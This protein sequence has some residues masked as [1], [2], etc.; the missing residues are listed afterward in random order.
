MKKIKILA[1]LAFVAITSNV[2][3]QND[4]TDYR[5]ELRFGLKAGLNY[6]NVY[7]EKTEDFNSD[8]K[9]GFVGG[10]FLSIPINKYLGVQPEVLFSQ[11]GF[12]GDGR[13]LGSKYEF[14]RT[15]S[16]IDVPIQ[17]AFKPS[18]FLTVLAGPQYSYLMNQKDDFNSSMMSYSQE[19]E[20]KNNNIR[21][22]I[23]G[24]VA[25]LDINIKNVIIGTRAGWD[26][27][28][29]HGDGSSNT[30]RYKNMWFQGT[31]GYAFGG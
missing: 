2:M 19:Q 17:V 1:A 31:I 30:P 27:Q 6:S 29:N 21:K 13:I 5:E 22:N 10:A 18:E 16:Y 4:E 24:I 14:T 9:F 23:L 26:I 7:D 15:T 8:A 3:A 20:F 25:G 12:K 28:N 11:K